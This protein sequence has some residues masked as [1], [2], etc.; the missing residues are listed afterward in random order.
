MALKFAINLNRLKQKKIKE[1]DY[2]AG[3]LARMT[4]MAEIREFKNN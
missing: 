3:R 1:K 4:E 2:D